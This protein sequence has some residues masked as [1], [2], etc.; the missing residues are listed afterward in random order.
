[1][2]IVE[3]REYVDDL[4]RGMKVRNKM[5]KYSD[6]TMLV[7]NLEWILEPEARKNEHQN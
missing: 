2:S 5:T 1:M 7:E 6:G 3:E 4:G